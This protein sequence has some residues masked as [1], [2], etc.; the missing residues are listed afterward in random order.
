MMIEEQA[1]LTDP[2]KLEFEAHIAQKIQADDGQI[3]VILG[4]TYFY[5]TG[6][7]QMHDTG[8]LGEANVVD[9]YKTEAGHV[10][11]RLDRDVSGA[12]LPAQINAQRRWGHMQHHS[13]QHIL[14]GALEKLLGLETLSVKIRADTLSTLDV[15]LR[16][17]SQVDLAGVERL[18]ND[19]IFENRPIKSYFITDDQIDTVPFRRPPQIKGPIRVVEVDD[20]DYSACGGTHCLYTGMIGLIKILKTEHKNKKLRLHFAAGHQV[21]RYFQIYHSLVTEIGRTL[22]TAPE[23]VAHIVSQQVE[24]LQEAQ[25]EIKKLRREALSFEVRQLVNQAEQFKAYR[26]VIAIFDQR[27]AHELHELGKLLQYEA[28]VIGA[29]ASY[30][31]QKLLLV[32][33]CGDKTN[34]SARQ[35]LA[36]QLDQIG[37]QGGGDNRIAQGG[38]PATERQVETFFDSIHDHILAARK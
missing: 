27:P 21:L 18:A 14:S 28:A 22:S 34:V 1:Y 5:P 31:G 15:P 4:R 8:T 10:G 11:H 24:Q 19:I 13:A 23:D 9:V 3:E 2:L 7:G 33:S 32:V 25:R 35:L 30:D 12:V 20:F 26:L 37:G 16:E 36:S 29:V 6:G 17:I 38:G